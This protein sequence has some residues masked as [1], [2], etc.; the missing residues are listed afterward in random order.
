MP[1][2][3]ILKT[4]KIGCNTEDHNHFD[5]ELIMYINSVI[6][7]LTELGVGPKEGF[8]VTNEYD[9]WSQWLVNDRENILKMVAAYVVM[10][11]KLMWDPPSSSFVL[12][13]IK[14]KTK[15][16]EWRIQAAVDPGKAV[17]P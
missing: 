3:S 2:D 12:E 8:F 5:Q 16:Y 6:A 4:V 10:S 1:E 11:V 14:E 9:T 13:S 7:T 17:T 15:E